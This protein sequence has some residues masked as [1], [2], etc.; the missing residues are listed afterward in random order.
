M[1][2]EAA[3]GLPLHAGAVTPW[4]R[5]LDGLGRLPYTVGVGSHPNWSRDM[6]VSDQVIYLTDNG[7]AYCGAHLGIT[8]RMTGL[9]L[10]GQ[11][12]MPVT[13]EAVAEAQSMGWEVCC[14]QCGKKPS[15]LHVAV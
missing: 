8:A 1:R 6:K 15:R 11:P 9:D 10:S 13:P 3:G 2:G 5:V 4:I 12:I 7:A 14:E